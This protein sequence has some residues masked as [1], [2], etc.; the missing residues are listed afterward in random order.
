MEYKNHETNEETNKN[1]FVILDRDIYQETHYSILYKPFELEVAKKT[2]TRNVGFYNRKIADENK[3]K[4]ITTAKERSGAVH[5]ILDI[6][7]LHKDKTTT[8]EA[9]VLRSLTV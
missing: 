2:R 1:K 9:F 7:L 3:K 8:T 5:S 6:I 4:L